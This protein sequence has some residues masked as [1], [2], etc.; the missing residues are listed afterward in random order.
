MNK[1][2]HAYYVPGNVLRPGVMK[3][4]GIITTLKELITC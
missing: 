3:I 2:W 4:Y 1:E